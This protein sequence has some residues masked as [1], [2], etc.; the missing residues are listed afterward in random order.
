LDGSQNETGHEFGAVTI[1]VVDSR[2]AAG[3]I[4]HPVFAE[5]RRGHPW[6]DFTDDNVVFRQLDSCGETESK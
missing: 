4:A 3:C 1:G 6:V 2:P 5:V